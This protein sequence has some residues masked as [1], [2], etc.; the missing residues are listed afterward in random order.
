MWPSGRTSQRGLPTLGESRAQRDVPWG[1]RRAV[2]G[3]GLAVRSGLEHI[4]DID[5][6]GDPVG[7]VDIG[8]GRLPFQDPA[9]QRASLRCFQDLVEH[10]VDQ[11]LQAEAGRVCHVFILA[12]RRLPVSTPMEARKVPSGWYFTVTYGT[13]GYAFVG[14]N[15]VQESTWTHPRYLGYVAC[16][17]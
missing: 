3:P 15:K 17:T 2:P 13:V 14:S 7:V 4:G 8:M 10:V 9:D 1:N 12:G 6:A 5:P 16:C 11:H